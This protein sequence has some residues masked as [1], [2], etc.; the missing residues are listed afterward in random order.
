[1][2]PETV[3]VELI[4]DEVLAQ[5]RPAGGD[6]QIGAEAKIL[7]AVLLFADNEGVATLKPGAL[8]HWCGRSRRSRASTEFVARRIQHLTDA[9]VLAPGSTETE[10][11]SMVGRKA[12]ENEEEM[13]A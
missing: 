13:A 11:R 7:L 2:K 6:D 10:L 5:L 12:D 4:Y 9:G 1:M 3:P 8:R